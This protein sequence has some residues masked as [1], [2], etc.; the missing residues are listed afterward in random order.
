MDSVA[1]DSTGKKL[2]LRPARPRSPGLAPSPC[3][4]QTEAEASPCEGT[5]AAHFPRPGG[6]G[7]FCSAAP[8]PRQGLRPVLTS[9]ARGAAAGFPHQPACRAG[10]GGPPQ[11]LPSPRRLRV[12]QTSSDVAFLGSLDAAGHVFHRGWTFAVTVRASPGRL[13]ALSSSPA[14]APTARA[15]TGGEA[16]GPFRPRRG[17]SVLLLSRPQAGPFLSCLRVC[18]FFLLPLASPGRCPL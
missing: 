7:L 3:S 16:H 2:L 8:A 4:R 1:F 9:Q 15:G 5:L 17:L 12:A 6:P 13:G 10:A 18:C 14:G 11:P